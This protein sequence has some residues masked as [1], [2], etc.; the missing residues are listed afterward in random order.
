MA[1]I[2]PMGTPDNRRPLAKNPVPL[3]ERLNLPP[4]E[5]SRKKAIAAKEAHEAKYPSQ[6]INI[7]LPGQGLELAKRIAEKKGMPYQTY[8][9]SLIHQGLEKEKEILGLS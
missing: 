1:L 3:S 4:L 8:L 9:K 6:A 2:E 7:R 5:D